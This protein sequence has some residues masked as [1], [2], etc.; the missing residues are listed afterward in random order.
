MSVKQWTHS[1]IKLSDRDN[2]AQTHRWMEEI[3]HG[4][5]VIREDTVDTYRD[6]F[7]PDSV[8]KDRC[9]ITVKGVYPGCIV[10]RRNSLDTHQ[11]TNPPGLG[12]EEEYRDAHPRSPNSDMKDRCNITHDIKK[13]DMEDIQVIYKTFTYLT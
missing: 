13:H 11:D 12:W 9:N 3:C 2:T 1:L 8:Q 5:T 7:L 4:N 10:I 6:T